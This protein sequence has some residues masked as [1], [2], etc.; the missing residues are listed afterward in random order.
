[1][2][3]HKECSANV[4]EEALRDLQEVE[5]LVAYIPKHKD[6]TEFQG[7]L[8]ELIDQLQDLCPYTTRGGLIRKLVAQFGDAYFY[9]NQ[10]GDLCFLTDFVKTA[11]SA[12]SEFFQ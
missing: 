12:E 7:H 3:S 10:T 2:D 11:H 4:E 1:M 6:D 5:Q 8:F 9:F